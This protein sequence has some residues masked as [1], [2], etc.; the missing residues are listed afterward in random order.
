[1]R[2]NAIVILRAAPLGLGGLPQGG[3]VLFLT[4]GFF[5]LLGLTTGIAALLGL[6]PGAWIALASGMQLGL[7]AMVMLMQ[8]AAILADPIDIAVIV[9]RPVPGREL[10]A[11]RLLHVLLLTA[12]LSA[13]F[14]CGSAFL[15]SF[16][17]PAWAM[18]TIYPLLTMLCALLT[19]GGIA[20]GFAAAVWIFGPRSFQRA[21][22][23]FQVL[24]VALL[25]AAYQLTPVV[26]AERLADLFEHHPR[27][28]FAFP[29]LNYA[30]AFALATGRG[31]TDNL[32]HTL[33]AIALPLGLLALA[34]RLA[35]RRF[36]A[37]LEGELPP[38]TART[39]GWPSGPIERLG[40]DLTAS[41]A[42]RAAFAL[43][44]AVARSESDYLRNVL[45]A[46]VGTL[47]MC[48]VL[49]FRITAPQSVAVFC[50]VLVF[51]LAPILDRARTSVDAEAAWLLDLARAE[52]RDRLLRGAI[53]G[54]LCAVLGPATIA[55]ALFV[56]ARGGIEVVPHALL[57]LELVW[58][59]AL[60]FAAAAASAQPFTAPS[61]SADASARSVLT[62]IGALLAAALTGGLHFVLCLHPAALWGGIVL[63]LPLLRLAFLSLERARR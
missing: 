51:H 14:T 7:L 6:E 59:A 32:I 16:A 5:W 40:A 8:Y 54:L 55:A 58:A 3:L 53:K 44:A 18:L 47:V 27:L 34:L 17:Y 22:L 24:V 13:A 50:V 4:L 56:V 62:W 37:A 45:P 2:V 20:L 60:L 15:A 46:L 21:T 30:G 11:A 39:R 9:S 35:A 33:L 12:A 38:R 25:G 29:P 43:T 41:S 26:S 61:R 28:A 10:F 36:V 31:T 48:A 42:E 1:V 63:G 52:D 57:G 19:L 23:L 49:S